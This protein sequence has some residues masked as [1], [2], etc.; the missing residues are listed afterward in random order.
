MERNFRMVFSTV[1]SVL[2]MIIIS[3][4]A[5]GRKP[6]LDEYPIRVK[7]SQCV[8]KELDIS[9]GD[10]KLT[11]PELKALKYIVHEELVK[12]PLDK[13]KVKVKV[14]GRMKKLVQEDAELE[15][16]PNEEVD[17]IITVVKRRAEYCRE[18]GFGD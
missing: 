18:K 5:D 1:V 10:F 14:F 12:E 6:V 8:I 15:G 13:Q 4:T 7:I 11:A 2:M 16:L 17:K 9:N 3:T